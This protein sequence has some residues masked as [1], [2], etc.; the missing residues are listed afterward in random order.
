MGI[1]NIK[2]IFAKDPFKELMVSVPAGVYKYPGKYR[3]DTR[4]DRRRKPEY[5]TKY[6]WEEMKIHGFKICKYKV[7]QK[8]WND[9]M[10]EGFNRSKYL[11]DDFP[12]TVNSGEEISEFIYK[13]NKLTGKKYRLPT[14]FEWMWAA[15]GAHKNADRTPFSGAKCLK[16]IKEYT[17]LEQ[18]CFSVGKKKPNEIGL[19]DM[20]SVYMGE[21][22]DGFESKGRLPVSRSS[23]FTEG[24]PIMGYIDLSYHISQEMFEKTDFSDVDPGTIHRDFSGYSVMT[25]KYEPNALVSFRLVLD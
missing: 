1:F 15:L 8:Q 11:G 19:Y 23:I 17:E 13:L 9:I 5:S 10:G 4:T 7:T 12:V 16:E 25:F 6:S 3:V 18:P 2:K 21:V 24:I 20:Q 22:I 14:A